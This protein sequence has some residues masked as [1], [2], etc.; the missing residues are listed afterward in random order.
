MSRRISGRQISTNEASIRNLLCTGLPAALGLTQAILENEQYENRQLAERRDKIM[1]ERLLIRK[2]ELVNKITR[3]MDTSGTTPNLEALLAQILACPVNDIPKYEQVFD[4]IYGINIPI[5]PM[6]IRP[7]P[8]PNLIHIFGPSFSPS[9]QQPVRAPRINEEEKKVSVTF[10]DFKR[11]ADNSTCAIC[12]EK[13]K[14]DDELEIR[15][16]AHSFHKQCLSGWESSGRTNG[17]L[18]P[19]C[20]L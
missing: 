5:L 3:Q 10:K 20:R 1:K 17:K 15:H 16:C 7:V 6:V 13:Y 8:L 12:L 14:D 2:Q 18:C 19:C 9:A 11:E 4:E